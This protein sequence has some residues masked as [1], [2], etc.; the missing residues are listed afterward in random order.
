MSNAVSGLPVGRG[1]LYL[2]VAGAAWGTAGAAAS[3]V[4]RTSDMGP[5]T[6]SFWRCAL[7]LLLL[8]A[9]R[10]LSRRSRTATP[11]PRG[12]R[13]LRATA[14]GV[15]L[16]VV[17]PQSF[18]AAGKLDPAGTGVAIARVN[19]FNYIGFILG[20]AL[21]G[22][23]AEAANY[24]VAYAAPLVLAAAIFVLAPAFQPRTP[25]TA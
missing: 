9:A 23:I 4:Y 3:L 22:G 25:A 19:L 1:L 12:R 10:P 16:A 5:V 6:L 18:S 21:I 14:T 2:I 11:E 17:G 20:A 8:L 13:A 15:G 24:R 7:G